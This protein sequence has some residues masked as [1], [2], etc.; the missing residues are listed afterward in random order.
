MNIID[1]KPVVRCIDSSP[2]R[3]NCKRVNELRVGSLFQ[4][5]SSPRAVGT[6][7]FGVERITV[8]RNAVRRKNAREV[9]HSWAAIQASV[10]DVFNGL[11]RPSEITTN[12]VDFDAV[13]AVILRLNE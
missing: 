12:A 11:G 2:K 3:P 1:P 8:I 7:F 6:L 13:I 4:D 10:D 9:R 5:V